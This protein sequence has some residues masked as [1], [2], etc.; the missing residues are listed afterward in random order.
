M[1]SLLVQALHPRALSAVWDHSDFRHQLKERLGRTA[2][3]VAATTYGPSD[4]AHSSIERVNQIHARIQGLDLKGR[5]YVANQPD[6]ITWVH[7]AEVHAFLSAYQHL[8]LS[9]LTRGQC[10]Q[11][12]AEM[13]RVGHA[14]GATGLPCTR[15]R[16]EQA[17]QAHESE[18]SFDE[19]AQEV[20]RIVA[21]Y[22]VSDAD[23]PYMNAVMQAA[24]DIMPNWAQHL[25]GCSP[26][27]AWRVAL[28]RRALQVANL[29]IQSFLNRDGGGRH[30][31][32]PLGPGVGLP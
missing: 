1:S 16:V 25:A 30:R 20:W 13:S 18:L 19:R 4:L 32:A 29:P 17:L 7:L 5:P 9:P 2:Y 24:H 23:R 8:A 27:S 28:T 26:A 10:D 14:L 12:M 22:P 6:L 15:L 21:A 11:Y 3:F 31:L